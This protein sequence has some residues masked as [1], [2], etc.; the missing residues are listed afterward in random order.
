MKRL[1]ALIIITVLFIGPLLAGGIVTNTNQSA[2]FT[3]MLC[4]DASV[5]IDAVYYNP[6]GLTKISNGLHISLNNQTL[7]QWRSI[8]SNYPYLSSMQTTPPESEEYIGKVSAPVFPGVYAAFRFGKFA[9]SAGFNPVGGGGSATFETGIP[10]LEYPASDLVPMLAT[11]GQPVTDYYLDAK[12]E[13]TSVFFG[14][15]AN[16][17]YAIT[18]MISVAVG[19]RFVT[20]KETYAG[21]LRD[22]DITLGGI[23][24]PATDF[25]AAASAQ[26][27]TAATTANSG[28]TDL[29]AQI[30]AGTYGLTDPLTDPVAQARLTGLGINWTGFDNQTALGAFAAAEASATTSAAQTAAASQALA[31]QEVDAEKTATGFTPIVSVNISPIDMLNIALK[32]EFRTK[33][34]F[35]NSADA[36]K[37]GLV[38]FDPLTGN[39]KYLF[40]D[41]AKTHLDMPAM[42]SAGVSVS[43]G[44]ITVMG[45]FHYYF[46]KGVDWDGDEDYVERGS[47]EL[48]LGVEVPILPML[49]VSAGY[50]K[51][52]PGVKDEY[53]TDMNYTLRS[54]SVGGGLEFNISPLIDLNLGVS[55]TKYVDDTKTYQ[56]ELGGEGQSG[57]YSVLTETYA[58][59]V[60]IVAV[61]LN[62]HIATGD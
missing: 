36:D 8:K 43:P 20:A 14:Y 61:G 59:D 1:S 19:G 3:R 27:T 57:I 35:T 22:I 56:R 52:S 50:L 38:G 23:P 15:Q 37:Q 9:V 32:Y 53:Q 39:P 58:K 13:G 21:H 62:I 54:N 33:L 18:D 30:T 60:T 25:F 41:G 10:S 49:K 55:Y 11:Q 48:G 17:S 47:Y 7:W 2:M 29:Q 24:T 45:G 12:F 31:D 6:A 28:A 44:P 40:E 42:L 51:T 26:Y 34:E 5:Q 46:D 16:L 4:R